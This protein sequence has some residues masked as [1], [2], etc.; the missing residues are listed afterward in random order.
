MQRYTSS[1]AE[2]ATDGVLL[3]QYEPFVQQCLRVVESTCFAQDIVCSV[4][5]QAV[6]DAFKCHIRDHYM[7]FC[8]RALRLMY[9][10]GFVPWRIRTLPSGDKVPEALPLGSFEWN[11]RAADRD[12][13]R[14]K[15]LLRYEVTSCTCGVPL[16]EVIVHEMTPPAYTRA[17]HECTAP[18]AFVVKAYREYTLA[19]E[20][21]EVTP[22]HR[23]DCFVEKKITPSFTGRRRVEQPAAACLH[24]HTEN[25]R[26]RRAK[27]RGIRPRRPRGRT[28]RER[29]CAAQ[30]GKR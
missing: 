24:G 13:C 17:L 10:C 16:D 8:Q 28:R 18:M 15:P 4:R 20:R 12:E 19:C 14:A 9:F 27:R 23:T 22:Q 6:G 5:G 25:P 2:T 11:V 1:A 30:R 21:Q 3:L 29:V 7:P 26:K